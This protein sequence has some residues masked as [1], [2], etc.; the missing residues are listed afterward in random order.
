M[1]F[2]PYETV[3]KDLINL[4]L[5]EDKLPARLTRSKDPEP[6]DKDITPN[7]SDFYNPKCIEQYFVIANPITPNPVNVNTL[8][9]FKINKKINTWKS[10]RDSY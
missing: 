4:S 10:C 2:A 5:G 7:L 8:S 3:Y 9:A 1:E 6:R